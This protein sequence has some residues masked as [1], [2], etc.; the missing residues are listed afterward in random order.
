M[1]RQ[2]D[3]IS[4]APL[5]VYAEDDETKYDTERADVKSR[6]VAHGDVVT[7]QEERDLR[8]GL[9]QRHISMMAL[10]G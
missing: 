6:Y 9:H 7:E 10:A 2:E 4:V 5:P 3:V 8:R 1:P